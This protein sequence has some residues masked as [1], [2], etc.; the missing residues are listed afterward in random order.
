[1][2]TE[3][4][5]VRKLIEDAEQD[6]RADNLKKAS[7]KL[8]QAIQITKKIRNEELLKQISE[9]IAK[10]SYS[11]ETQSIE[12]SPIKTDGFILDIGGGGEG[13]IGRLNGKQVIAIDTSEKEL[14]ETK[15]EALKVVMDATNLKFLSKSFDVC[16]AFFSFMY[17]PNDDHLRVFREV[18]RVLKNHGK[19]LIWDVKIPRE[20]WDYK[21][22]TVRLKIRLLN[23]EVETGYGSKWH[24][25]HIEYFK[26][27]AQK[28]KFKI[29]NE[30]SKGEI[31]Y[32]EM[33][34]IV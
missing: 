17:I 18:Y 26:Q 34:K 5:E 30:W 1:M 33:S 24:P 16:T 4:K 2:S 29:V 13:I 22:F 19:F 27:L 21:A 28:T 9:L 10:F 7:E 25:Q 3:E 15:N 6:I 11:T 31:F 8:G 12:L 23:E 32:L 14:E 20:T